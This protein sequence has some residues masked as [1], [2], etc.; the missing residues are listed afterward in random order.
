MAEATL[1]VSTTPMGDHPRI[2]SVDRD[3]LNTGTFVEVDPDSPSAVA[4]AGA[5]KVGVAEWAVIVDAES[6]TELARRADR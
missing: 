2:V 3:A 6:A 4:Q 5:G 1:F